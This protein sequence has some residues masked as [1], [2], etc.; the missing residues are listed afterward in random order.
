ML[1]IFVAKPREIALLRHCLR[2]QNWAR[3]SLFLVV[4]ELHHPKRPEPL[5]QP[6]WLTIPD[7][8]L[9]TGI[10]IVGAIRSRKT[11]LLHVSIRRARSWHT[12]RAML[13]R[14]AG[15]VLEV[16]GDFRHKALKSSTIERS[17]QGA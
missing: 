10:V 3:V 17:W 6:R 7:R 13:T 15:L 4:A 5:E 11:K 14:P 16:K 8:G 12:K 1:F 9:Y 2:I